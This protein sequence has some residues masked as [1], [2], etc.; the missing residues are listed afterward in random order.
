M[1]EVLGKGNNTIDLIPGGSRIRVTDDNKADFIKKKCHYIGYKAVSEQLQSLQEGFNKVIPS[2]WV[3]LFTPDEIE[4]AICGNPHIDL[5]DWKKH[6]EL[7]GY[8]MISMT[9]GRF[10]KI[11]ETYSQVELQRI[12][13]FCTGTSR[14]PLGGFK[15]LES[16]RGEKAKFCIQRVTYDDDPKK[17][18]PLGNLPKAHT[19]FNRLDL[20]RYPS[21]NDMKVAM[22]YIAKND[23]VGFGMEE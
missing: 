18:G 19:C 21:Y 15:S 11:M 17:G 4:A 9:I 10:W 20:P 7:K 13:Q 16:H 12:L 1:T 3:S 22:D 23:I 14:L 2:S 8:G 6:T 5:E